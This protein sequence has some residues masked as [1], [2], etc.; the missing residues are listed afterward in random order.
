MSHPDE[1]SS[2]DLRRPRV[3]ITGCAYCNKGDHLQLCDCKVAYFCCVEHKTAMAAQ[4]SG[5][6]QKV[7]DGRPFLAENPLRDSTGAVVHAHETD[8]YAAFGLRSTAVYK[9]V[10]EKLATFLSKINTKLA[11]EERLAILIEI[12]PINLN[13]Q[14]A[15]MGL[16]VRLGRDHEAYNIVSRCNRLLT[17]QNVELHGGVYPIYQQLIREKGDVDPWGEV[18]WLD[19]DFTPLG[20]VFP[21]ILIKV[22]MLIDLEG[23]QVTLTRF[24]FRVPREVLDHI[25]SFVPTSSF[26]QND[27]AVLHGDD[28]TERIQLLRHQIQL[29]YDTVDRMDDKVWPFVLYDK[30]ENDS[31]ACDLDKWHLTN[32]WREIGNA[33]LETPGALACIARFRHR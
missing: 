12:Y 33:W 5:Y 32:I 3:L 13:A 17:S 14:L 29:L 4:H 16:M 20:F 21:F 22:K 27:L 1:G 24:G 31:R 15:T 18:A 10:R 6:C 25:R 23:L 19:D 26:I 8:L 28:H 30:Y 2:P 9:D 7:H 11:A